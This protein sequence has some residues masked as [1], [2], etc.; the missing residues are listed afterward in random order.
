VSVRSHRR[1]RPVTTWQV[2]AAKPRDSWRVASAD[3]QATDPEGFDADSLAWQ[4]SLT[5]RARLGPAPAPPSRPI[6]TTAT[7]VPRTWSVPASSVADGWRAQ[8][9][10]ARRMLPRHAVRPTSGHAGHVHDPGPDGDPTDPG[11]P[12]HP[13]PHGDPSIRHDDLATRHDDPATR[14]DDLATRQGDPATRHGDSAGHGDQAD[15]AGQA[16]PAG[17]GDQADPADLTGA[18]GHQPSEA[19]HGD[20]TLFLALARQRLA[21]GIPVNMVHP[22]PPRDPALSAADRPPAPEPTYANVDPDDLLATFARSVEEA[23]GVCHQVVGQVPDTLLDRLVAELDAWD[24]VVSQDPEAVALG[25]RLADRG[26][27]VS[28][29]RRDATTR[30][31]LGVTS[32]VAGIAAT[33]SVVLDSARSG[34]RLASVLPPAHLCVLPVERLVATPADVLRRL[35]DEPTELPSSLV[36]V[37]GPSRTGDIEQ[38]LT[39]GAHGPMALHVIVVSPPPGVAPSR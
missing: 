37:T 32:A 19:E 28:P 25:E 8:T 24:V 7:E 35:G 18:V 11:R 33:G 20:R 17:H 26:V 6:E 30:A 21:G 29:A 3:E 4:L 27:E 34:G 14:H 23:G 2:P 15:A 5:V 16:D 10:V 22:P 1:P 39:I 38:L 31:A 36:L 12:D 9:P 13:V